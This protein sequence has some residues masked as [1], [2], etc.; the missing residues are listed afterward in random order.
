VFI[1]LAFW[2]PHFM[3]FPF[4]FFCVIYFFMDSCVTFLVLLWR[5]C[6]GSSLTFFFIFWPFWFYYN[7]SVEVRFRLFFN[8][9]TDLFELTITSL[10][11]I[12][13]DFFFLFKL[14]SDRFDFTKTLLSR[15]VFDFF[16]FFSDLF[17]FTITLLSRIVFDFFLKS[18]FFWPF[19][20]YFNVIV[21]VRFRLFFI[22]F[23]NFIS[24]LFDFTITLLSRFV[25]DFF[26]FFF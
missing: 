26:Y 1:K 12:F 2:L 15:F 22:F 7:I 23:L 21:E 4:L 9:F 25:F 8:F 16:I 3:S 11:R 6:R 18:F 14:F 5:Y 17:D 20:F 24:D 10:S 13:F 19:W